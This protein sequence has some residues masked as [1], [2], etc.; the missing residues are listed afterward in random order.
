MPHKNRK[1][2]TKRAI[3]EY[4][5]E[6]LP[7]HEVVHTTTPRPDPLPTSVSSEIDMEQCGNKQ[8]IICVKNLTPVCV[9]EEVHLYFFLVFQKIFVESRQCMVSW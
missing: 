3:R 2:R 4:V 9:D 5:C 1:Q 7:N 6:W 8:S